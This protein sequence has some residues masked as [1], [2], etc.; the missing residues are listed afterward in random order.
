[1]ER[2]TDMKASTAT[3][4]VKT[5]GC[6]LGDKKSAL[7]ALDPSGR[8]LFQTEVK[9]TREE[10]RRYFSGIEKTEVV[11]E[12]GTHS[13]WVSALVKSLGHKVTVINPHEFKLLTESRR[14][15]DE[16]DAQLLAKVHQAD[17]KLVKSVRHR[18]EATRLQLASL[19][20]RDSLVKTRTQLIST[21][22]GMLK[23][24]GA[25]AGA[26]DAKVFHKRVPAFI[27]DE[28]KSALMPLVKVLEKL[29]EEMGELDE[30]VAQMAEREHEALKPLMSI[31][32]VGVLTALTFRLVVEDPR[33][34]K[35]SRDVGAYLGLT[36]GRK[37]SGDRDV[38][39]GITKQGDEMLRRLLVQCA[40]QQTFKSA[41]DTALKRWALKKGKDGGKNGK[42]RVAV[43]VARKLAVLMH[44][45]W[46]GN[47]TFQPFPSKQQEA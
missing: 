19:R 14:K 5:L 9:T 35:N 28:L 16:A 12:V 43:A 46:R 36:P 39:Q 18:E 45:L 33:R 27:P 15:S 6:D 7:C 13:A 34:F 21:V 44:R 10:V 24:F 40:H 22:R 17:L 2:T 37:Q 29:A 38:Q 11:M 20:T 3:A 30:A 25:R 47:D 4:S 1:M 41:P 32:R 23:T 42:K 8:V 26:C 31:P